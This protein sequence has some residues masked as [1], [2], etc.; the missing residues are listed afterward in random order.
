[1]R[2]QLSS[3]LQNKDDCPK[4]R[5]HTTRTLTFITR[6]KEIKLEAM[7]NSIYPTPFI[8]KF[9][10]NPSQEGILNSLTFA[11]K[12]VFNIKGYKTGCGNP[13]WHDS[14]PI[15]EVNAICIDQLLSSGEKNGMIL[16]MLKELQ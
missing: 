3:N 5:R 8:T 6:Q 11:V 12:D 1:M 4:I 7:N 16:F 2:R 10:M 15:S 13:L 9:T 14:Q